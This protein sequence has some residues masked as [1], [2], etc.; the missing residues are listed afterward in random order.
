MNFDFEI[1]EINCLLI[2]FNAVIIFNRA[3]SLF[4]EYRGV[5]GGHEPLALR[6]PG[7]EGFNK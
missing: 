7:S 4:E 3:E 5:V 6:I 2:A 1:A